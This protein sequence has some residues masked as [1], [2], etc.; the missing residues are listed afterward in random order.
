MPTV[1]EG[2]GVDGGGGGGHDS[3]CRM[4]SNGEG[5][6]AQGGGG[7]LCTGEFVDINANR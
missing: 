4:A 3:Y 1:N 7:G 2:G 6:F 5:M